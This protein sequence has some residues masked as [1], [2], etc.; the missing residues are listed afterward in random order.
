MK[1]ELKEYNADDKE[2]INQYDEMLDETGGGYLV[3][4]YGASRILKEVDP[5]A[6]NCGMNDFID[7]LPEVWVCNECGEEYDT[8]EEAEGCCIE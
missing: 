8:E 3:E 5:I 6:Y 2:I 1:A 7:I 4:T